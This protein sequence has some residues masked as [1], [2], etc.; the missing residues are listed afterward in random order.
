MAPHCSGCGLSIEDGSA[1]CQ[2][3]FEELTARDFSDF[4]YGKYHRLGVDSY[5]LQHPDR[6]CISPKSFMAHLGGLC[7]AFNYAA[8]P[9]AYRALQRSL[10]APKLEK[11]SL[12]TFRGRVTIADVLRTEDPASYGEEI[13]RWA[14][15]VWD[16]YVEL[17][18]F[19]ES[20]LRKALT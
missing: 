20:W 11:P 14:R 3:L 16:A 13:Q 4:R 17:Q 1:G 2:A 6:Y 9:E 12:P 10:N 19:A 15:S 8:D 5:C 18:P 7:C